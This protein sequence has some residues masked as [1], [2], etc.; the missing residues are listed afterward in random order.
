MSNSE[1]DTLAN[2]PEVMRAVEVF[3]ER[4]LTGADYERMLQETAPVTLR[5]FKDGN[6][7]LEDVLGWKTKTPHLVI[8]P[9][10]S[11]HF[12]LSHAPSGCAII[13]QGAEISDLHHLAEILGRFDWSSPDLFETHPDDWADRLA[14]V[15]AW[16]EATFFAV[17]DGGTWTVRA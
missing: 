10:G 11:S 7:V 5:K 2:D 17:D 16:Y 13:N 15:T 6:T 1:I 14:A 8:T 3:T 4:G 12:L 9:E